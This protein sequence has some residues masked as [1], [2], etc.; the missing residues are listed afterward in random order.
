MQLTFGRNVRI[1]SDSIDLPKSLQ[2]TVCNHARPFTTAYAACS[3][4]GTIYI[5]STDSLTHLC[6][7]SE[8]WS[9]RLAE[10]CQFAAF[11][12]RY[13]WCAHLLPAAVFCVHRPTDVGAA[14]RIA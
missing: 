6:K 1:V 9:G 11:K 8:R 14:Y 13:S 2:S 5:T 7:F 3:D 10:L 12:L 4:C